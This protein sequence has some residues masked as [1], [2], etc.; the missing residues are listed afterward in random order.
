MGV[1]VGVGVGVCVCLC[2]H[3]QMVFNACVRKCCHM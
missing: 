3:K 1:G 2:E